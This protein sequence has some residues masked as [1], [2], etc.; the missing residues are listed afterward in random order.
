LDSDPATTGATWLVPRIEP[1]LQQSL[2]YWGNGFLPRAAFLPDGSALIAAYDGKIRRIAVPSGQV[3]GIPFVADI[4]QHLAPLLRF[5]ADANAAA[6]PMVTARIVC[7]VRLSPD[8]RKVAFVALDRIW[9]ADAEDGMPKGN[10]FRV[11][12]RPLASGADTTEHAPAWS[13]DGRWL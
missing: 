11:T 7:N 9:V 4:E 13:P 12:D 8:G 1:S 5:P 6:D 10:P 2:V 3:T